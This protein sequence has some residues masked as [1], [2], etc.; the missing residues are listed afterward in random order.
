ME[1]YVKVFG[2]RGDVKSYIA[3]DKISN[4]NIVKYLNSHLGVAIGSLPT[5]LP[6]MIWNKSSSYT[7]Y[8]ATEDDVLLH[9]FK[10]IQE[11]L[12]YLKS[13]RNLSDVIPS[14]DT[15]DNSLTPVYILKSEIKGISIDGYK[16]CKIL[17]ISTNREIL[18][19]MKDSYHFASNTDYD[20]ECTID[21]VYMDS[22][23]VENQIEL[24][25]FFTFLSDL[26][27]Y[28]FNFVKLD[29]IVYTSDEFFD[30]ANKFSAKTSTT[31]GFVESFFSK[32]IMVE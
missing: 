25:I 9:N 3:L 7:R 11:V 5:K 18:E 1:K 28:G 29:S 22:L 10:N 31:R 20:V 15:K 8:L 16:P 6:R 13:A 30:K 27:L 21:T 2:Y 26:S 17:N 32:R 23:K 14:D 4:D 24:S 19:N 12:N